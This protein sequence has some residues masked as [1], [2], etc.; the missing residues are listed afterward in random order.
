MVRDFLDRVFNGAAE[1]LLVHLL[2]D[3]RL[4]QR[5]LEALARRVR[6]VRR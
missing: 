6:A 5:D 2:E 3:R 4:T 1:P